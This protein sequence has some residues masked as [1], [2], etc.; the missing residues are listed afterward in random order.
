MLLG[1]IVKITQ[2][3]HRN[4]AIKDISFDSR[5][6]KKNDVFFAIDGTKTSGAKFIK[7]A[8]KKGAIAIVSS[9]RIKNI[10]N[11]IPNIIVRNTREALSKAC[12]KFYKNKPKNIIAVTGTNGKSSVAHFF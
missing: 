5:T 7:E 4:I 12:S 3:N 9:R 6:T 2:K 1:Q 11:K 10:N 8:I